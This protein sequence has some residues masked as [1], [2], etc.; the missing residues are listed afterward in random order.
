MYLYLVVWIVSFVRCPN[1]LSDIL[2]GGGGQLLQGR[3]TF[4]SLGA[5][6]I[7]SS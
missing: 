3:S 7:N 6:D 2:G 4:F 5:T 1:E